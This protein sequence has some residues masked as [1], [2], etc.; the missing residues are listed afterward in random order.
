MMHRLKLQFPVSGII[1][2]VLCLLGF[3]TYSNSTR[4]DTGRLAYL[5]MPRAEDKI[6]I[7]TPHPDDETIAAG[8]YIY[9]AC[10]AGSKIR[11]VMVTD[12]NKHG[13]REKR[14]HEF[15]AAMA[16]LGVK[17]GQL[18]FWGYKD[19]R[20]KYSVDTLTTRL[21]NEIDEYHPNV[22]IYPHPEDYH[23]DHAVLG[24]VAESSLTQ[25]DSKNIPTAYRYLVHYWFF[26]QP[27]IMSKNDRLDPPEEMS[28]PDQQWVR[29]MLSQNTESKKNSAVHLYATQLHNP[30][31]K[32]LLLGF[33]RDN[34]LFARWT[35]SENLHNRA[36]LTAGK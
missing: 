7:L 14:Y 13:L 16:C 10:K 23:P 1:V 2:F 27:E 29:F 18:E 9:E 4:A 11:I 35:P 25:M 20:L 19:G 21:T 3:Y 15:E 5:P 28:S 8:G 31:L 30:F 22:F 34:E 12:G 36:S 24:H 17:P 33:I 6:L 32:P 26:P